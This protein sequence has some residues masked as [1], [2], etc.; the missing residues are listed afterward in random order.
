MM[1]GERGFEP[2]PPWSRTRFSSLLKPVEFCCR[3]LIDGEALLLERLLIFVE[4]E[5]SHSLKIDY[6]TAALQQTR[7][8]ECRVAPGCVAIHGGRSSGVSSFSMGKY[9]PIQDSVH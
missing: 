8:M 2:P 9:R 6:R 4:S 1:V 7:C 5:R 3:Q